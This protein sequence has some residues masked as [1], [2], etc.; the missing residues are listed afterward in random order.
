MARAESRGLRCQ[1]RVCGTER[2]GALSGASARRLCVPWWPR[3]EVHHQGA[4]SPLG[5]E[6]GAGLRS[7]RPRRGDPASSG[8]VVH[9]DTLER[10]VRD[11]KRYSRLLDAE[12]RIRSA[13]PRR[14][15]IG[16]IEN[17]LRSFQPPTVSPT[18]AGSTTAAGSPKIVYASQVG[19]PGV[20]MASR[21]ACTAAPSD[22]PL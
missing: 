20:L 3:F 22:F 9:P 19:S 1:G 4:R 10:G 8:G 2:S 16:L 15:L 18:S 7:T 11:P 14:R 13:P 6:H 21:A 5:E 17:F 12:S